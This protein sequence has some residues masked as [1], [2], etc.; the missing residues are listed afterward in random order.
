MI[1][2]PQIQS[3]LDA[4]ATAP[5]PDGEPS[6]EE[7]RAGARTGHVA[8]SPPA[9]ESVE[10]RTILVPGPNGEIPCLVDI[11]RATERALPVL[12]YFHG[13]GCVLLDAE[14][15]NPTCT[16]IADQADCIVVNVDFRLAP[17]HPF[18]APLDDAFAAYRWVVENAGQFGG[19]PSLVAVGGDSGGGYLAAAV[20]LDAKTHGVAQPVRQVLVYPAVDMADRSESMITVDAFLNDDMVRGLNAAHVGDQI[21]DPRASPLRASDHTGLAP[22]FILAAGHDP[23]LDQGRAYVAILRRAGVDVDY[24]VYDGVV[25][26]FFTWGAAVDRAN[27]AVREVAADLRAA[28]AR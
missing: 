16:Q 2:D 19:D 14:A 20:C 4:M 1:L 27:D 22:A 28:F 15:F 7:M 6:L 17:E 3:V 5:R 21:L 9:V 18:P 12:V 13:G 26:A 11:P 8:L 23:L 10:V 24:R 25:H